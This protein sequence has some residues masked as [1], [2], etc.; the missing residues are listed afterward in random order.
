[1]SNANTIIMIPIII[2]DNA[3]TTIIITIIT[4]AYC[5]LPF[6]TDHMQCIFLMLAS[7]EH[8]RRASGLGEHGGLLI[9]TTRQ[10][11]KIFGASV[12]KFQGS[13]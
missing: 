1:M 7:R 2:I 8:A 13:R 12:C 5:L 6:R 4:T 11:R 3:D 9:L 10:N